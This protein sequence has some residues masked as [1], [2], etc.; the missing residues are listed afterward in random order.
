MVNKQHF[1]ITAIGKDRPGIVSAV[2]KVLY[3][4]AC[5]IED[6]SMTI[7]G[8]E[9]AV[10]MIVSVSRAKKLN[11]AALQT[12]FRKVE[13]RLA[14]SIHAKE[15][16]RP[17]RKDPAGKA[18]RTPHMVSLLGTD[19]PGLV[20]RVAHLLARRKINITDVNTKLVGTAKNPVYAMLIEVELPERMQI[21]SLQREL[22][23]LGKKL[24]AD[25][26]IKPVDVFQL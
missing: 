20:F 8:G 24:N 6:S 4:N 25:I 22:I 17:P 2:A 10:I 14:L 9:F 26:T 21:V 7:L 1:V 13:K 11:Q 3:K 16:K 19:K 23:R 15:L 18:G 12:Q 5:N